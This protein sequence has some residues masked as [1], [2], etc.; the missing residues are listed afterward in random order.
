MSHFMFVL[1]LYIE[2]SNISWMKNV[3]FLR[4]MEPLLIWSNKNPIDN[5][6]H[7]QIQSWKCPLKNSRGEKVNGGLQVT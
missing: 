2:L 3:Y 6:G 4:N 5:N 1:I 7:D